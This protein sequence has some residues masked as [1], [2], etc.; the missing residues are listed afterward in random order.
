MT[1]V[2]RIIGQSVNFFHRRAVTEATFNWTQLSTTDYHHHPS[3]TGAGKNKK[4]NLVIL[5][6]K[7]LLASN[8]W[9]LATVPPWIS[10]V[11]DLITS[12][13]ICREYLHRAQHAIRACLKFLLQEAK[14]RLIALRLGSNTCPHVYKGCTL[15]LLSVFFPHKFWRPRWPPTSPNFFSRPY[16]QQHKTRLLCLKK[17]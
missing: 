5:G 16:L 10:V 2:F 11:R 6:T 3:L 17:R 4:E 1:V 9:C 13:E 7:L 14:L 12:T 15:L 8:C